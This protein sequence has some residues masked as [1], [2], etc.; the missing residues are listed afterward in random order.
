MSARTTAILLALGA[1][2]A[3]GCTGEHGSPAPT[4]SATP[5]ASASAPAIPN[6]APMISPAAAHALIADSCLSCHSEEMIAQQRL[7]LSQWT[8]VVKKMRGWGAPLEAENIEPLVAYLATIHGPAAGPYRVA[9]LSAEGA[10]AAIAPQPDGPFAGGN[11]G[12]GKATYHEL[13]AACHGEDARG[14]EMG[15]GL[16]DRPV[17]YRATDFARVV[18]LGRGRMPAF[19]D[20]DAPEPRIADVL[21]HL[22]TLR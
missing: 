10:A 12:R 5:V 16:A 9:T 17:L 21:A 1:A 22:R 19:R 4:P 2:I 6:V 3:G 14:A 15:V 11:A 8:A 18:R 20:Q 7:T 13:C